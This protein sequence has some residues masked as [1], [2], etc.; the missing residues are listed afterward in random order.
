V[1][2][3]L[4]ARPDSKVESEGSGV[5]MLRTVTLGGAVL[6]ERLEELDDSRWSTSY[7]MPVTGPFPV[8]DYVST[9]T[10]TPIGDQRCAMD[11]VGRF[12]PAG[13]DEAASAAA[14]REVYDGGT[15]V[16][17]ERFGS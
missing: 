12:A 15:A 16:L 11:W 5:G 8:K 2:V 14:V 6:V 17:R 3:L 9:I 7:S 1:E 13:G 10:L 4:A